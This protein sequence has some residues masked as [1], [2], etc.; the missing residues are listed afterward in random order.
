MDQVIRQ[1]MKGR[2]VSHKK[3]TLTKTAILVTDLNMAN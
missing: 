3:Y 2:D 1:S